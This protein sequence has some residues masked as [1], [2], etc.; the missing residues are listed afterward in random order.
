MCVS[1]SQR[2]SGSRTVTVT[3][4]ESGGGKGLPTSCKN[5]RVGGRSLVDACEKC[6]SRRRASCSPA[7]EARKESGRLVVFIL[8]FFP[9]LVSSLCF[10]S[11]CLHFFLC[12]LLL[13]SSSSYSF[14][15]SLL[16][17]SLS[18]SAS[19][20]CLFFPASLLLLFVSLFASSHTRC[21]DLLL[22]IS[23]SLIISLSGLPVAS[24]LS[25]SH[26]D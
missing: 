20:L 2:G 26:S 24:L 10:S 6:D 23:L 5:V 14:P 7:W 25:F 17:L 3:E 11:S 9:V 1:V 21:S 19:F 18:T 12:F 4:S 8:S 22:Y 15:S 13:I 16:S